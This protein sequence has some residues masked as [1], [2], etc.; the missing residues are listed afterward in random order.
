ML[1]NMRDLLS[2]AKKNEFT[3]GAFNVTEVSNFNCVYE[4][5]ERLQSPTII[6]IAVNELDFCGREFYTYVREKLMNSRVPYCL[7]LDHGDSMKSCMRAIQAGFTSVMFDGSHLPYEENVRQTKAVVEVAH[8]VGVS[9]E[10]ELGTIGDLG[11]SDEGGAAEIIYT[12]PHEAKDFVEKTGVDT[13]AIAI[14]TS[15]GLYPAGFKPQLQLDLLREIVKTVDLPLVLHGGSGQDDEQVK[16]ASKVGIQKINVASEYKAA[17]SYE[18]ARL[19][20]ETNDFKFSRLLPQAILAG[21]A[22]V[23]HKMTVFGSIN[24]TYLYYEG[25]KR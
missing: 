3:V 16:V 2:V 6:A 20:Q 21:S 25:L 9:V 12:Q 17:I 19:I 7:H 23:E 15:H 18:L 14:G 22:V 10:G 11:N 1:L 8:L 24:K 5:A 4:V 13:L